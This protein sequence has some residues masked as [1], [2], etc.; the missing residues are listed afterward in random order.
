MSG[1]TPQEKLLIW[2]AVA[3]MLF[4]GLTFLA[5]L[6]FFNKR[7]KDEQKPS[8]ATPTKPANRSIPSPTPAIF[9]AAISS[10]KPKSPTTHFI[11]RDARNA[12]FFV[13]HS[14][15]LWSAAGLGRRVEAQSAGSQ[16]ALP[17]RLAG[18]LQKDAH[19]VRVEL[20]ATLAGDFLDR[21]M[22]GPGVFL[23]PLV[24]EGVEDISHGDDAAFERNLLAG[25]PA[26][27]APAVPALVMSERDFGRQ[28]Q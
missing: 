13:R 26:W 11:A 25:Q 5:G 8:R 1:N 16:A 23:R 7:L 17:K 9:K 14:K 24:R 27:V 6:L 28:L 22:D 10:R 15:V 2:G 20:A 4:I 18:Q 3:F 12:A 19:H 21:F